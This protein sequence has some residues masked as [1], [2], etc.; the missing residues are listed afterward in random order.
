MRAAICD[1][2]PV[3]LRRAA[4]ILEAYQRKKE[5]VLE[6]CFYLNGEELLAETRSIDI[7]FLDIEMGKQ[8]GISV[9]AQVNEKWKNCS[10]VY[11]TDYLSYAVDVY[12]TKHTYYVLKNQF[13]DRLDTVYEK[14]LHEKKQQVSSIT[15][16]LI[17]GRVIQMAPAEILYFERDRRIT[18]IITTHTENNHGIFETKEKISDLE[19]KLPP[20]DFARCHNSYIVYFPAVK[21]LT[22]NAIIMNNGDT[23][24]ISRQYQGRMRDQFLAWAKLR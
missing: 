23:I 13:E 18:R 16:Q 17:D 15:L 12:D 20:L 9:A 1:D 11:L 21:E 10:I 24:D 4:S 3:W 7:L 5:I 2:D 6:L 19:A 22:K 8:D 14:I